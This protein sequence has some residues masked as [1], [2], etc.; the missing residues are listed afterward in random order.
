MRIIP[1]ID[2]IGG[3]C[4]RLVQGDYNLKKTY[5]KDPADMAK[6]FEDNGIVRLHIVDLDGARNKRVTNWRSLEKIAGSTS[7]IIDFG[8]GIKTDDDLQIVFEC[9]A[10]MAV[11]GSIAV[12]DIELFREWLLEYGSEKLIL[13]ADVRDKKISVSAWQETTTLDLIPFLT[14][15]SDMGVKQV[16]CTDIA[17]DGM[18]SGPSVGMY[19]EIMEKVPSLKLIASG[20]VSSLDD[21]RDLEEKHVPAVIIGKAIYEGKIKLNELRKFF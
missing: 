21:I 18:L 17:R 3:K 14:D 12:T 8:G 4:V 13:G 6:R 2:I 5:G 19:Q 11:A 20:G 10:S 7:L 15:Y 16:I 1:A 9:G